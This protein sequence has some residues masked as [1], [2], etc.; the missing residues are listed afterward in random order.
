MVMEQI[1]WLGVAWNEVG[2]RA[3]MMVRLY[4]ALLIFVWWSIVRIL[5]VRLER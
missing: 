5:S 1:Y 4:V 3:R 2:L